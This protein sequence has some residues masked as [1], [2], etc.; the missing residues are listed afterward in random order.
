MNQKS[1]ADRPEVWDNLWKSVK[2]I[3]I[4]YANQ[5]IFDEILKYINFTNKEVIELGCGTGRLSYLTYKQGAKKLILVDFSDKALD[6]AKK[7]FK[8]IDSIEF[9]KSD[10]LVKKRG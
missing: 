8:G 2:N 3:E 9:W 7:Q 5:G 1:K 6:L 10:I 4:N